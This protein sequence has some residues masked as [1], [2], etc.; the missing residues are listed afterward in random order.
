MVAEF[1]GV[2]GRAAAGPVKANACATTRVRPSSSGTR[3]KIRAPQGGT[4]FVTP[5]TWLTL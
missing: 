3:A 1:G 5:G 2:E 4:G